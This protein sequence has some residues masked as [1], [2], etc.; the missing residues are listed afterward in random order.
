VILGYIRKANSGGRK[1][2]PLSDFEVYA[3]EVKRGR[4]V[5]LDYLAVLDQLEME[6][7]VSS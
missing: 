5:P 7:A 6:R 2:I 3:Y 1:S 4:G